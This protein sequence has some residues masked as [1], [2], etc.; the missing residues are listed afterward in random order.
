FPEEPAESATRLAKDSPPAD[1]T[2]WGGGGSGDGDYNLESF[3]AAETSLADHLA[4]QL[5]VALSAPA[6][7]L[8]GSYLID[9]VDEAGYLP[10]DLGDA[11]ERLGAS[12]ADVERV[13]SVL[14]TF[15]PP[16]I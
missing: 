11:A 3:V 9:L 2:E 8:I 16:G 13:L 14:Q 6:D 15:D 4:G 1:Y 10:P 7:R 5:A 12:V